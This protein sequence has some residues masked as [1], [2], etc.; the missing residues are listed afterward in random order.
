[1][2]EDHQIEEVNK[3]KKRDNSNG[4]SVEV[5][6]EKAASSDPINTIIDNN[7]DTIELINQNKIT[8]TTIEQP[9]SSSSS[10]SS[11]KLTKLKLDN[12]PPQLTYEIEAVVASSSSLIELKNVDINTN[13][14]GESTSEV[15]SVAVNSKAIHNASNNNNNNNNH[16]GNESKHNTS[17]N[18]TSGT[19]FLN[20][21]LISLKSSRLK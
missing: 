17:N 5:K 1:M 8:N 16:S 20:F 2:D 21:F 18:Y 14:S 15:T 19:L 6:T 7:D 3:K 4:I 11:S 13:A 9:N 12:I 10:S